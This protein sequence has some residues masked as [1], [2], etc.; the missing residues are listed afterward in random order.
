M[1]RPQTK[2]NAE[3]QQFQ[4]D[5]LHWWDQNGPFAPLH[6]QNPARIK[7]IRD[8]I[9]GHYNAIK[10][11]KILDVGCGGGLACEPL[12]RLGADVTGIDADNQAIRVATEH[13][14]KQ[15]LDI[16]YI[17]AATEDLKT[18]TKYD[19]VMALEII[20]HV[21][22]PQAFVQDCFDLCKPGGL[23]IFSTLNRTAKSF[24]LGIVAAEYLLRW[25]PQGTHNWKKFVKPAELAHS[26][27]QCGGAVKSIKGIYFNILRNEFDIS[28]KDIDVNY[29]LIAEKPNP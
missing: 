9:L 8:H 29:Y 2:N 26:V 4:K 12:A 24:A 3:I 11:L 15:G 14:A 13:A 10:G 1:S 6:R 27:R 17:C 22:E 28:D 18:K 5:S 16:T 23:V 21:D 7:L 25:I 20:E 19:V